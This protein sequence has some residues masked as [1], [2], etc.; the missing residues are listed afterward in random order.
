MSLRPLPVPKALPLLGLLFFSL[1]SS[2]SHAAQWRP[3]GPEGASIQ[4]VA[5]GAGGAVYAVTSQ[6]NVAAS[7]D[8]AA[9]WSQRGRLLGGHDTLVA[10]PARPGILYAAIPGALL[11]SADGGATWSEP[12]TSAILWDFQIAPSSPDVLYG[13]GG[14]EVLKSTDGGVSWTSSFLGGAFAFALAIDPTNPLIVYTATLEGVLRSDDGG[15]HWGVLQGS[16]DVVYDLAID[17]R[18]PA[19]LYGLGNGEVFKST[20]RGA[21]WTRVWEAPAGSYILPQ[22]LIVD[23]GSETVYM[24]D[25]HTGIYGS[26]DGGASWARILSLYG[27][28]DLAVDGRT[29]G[30]LYAGT[31]AG[32]VYRSDDR[33]GTWA[34]ANHGLREL[35]FTGV[36]ADPHKPGVLLAIANPDPASF[37]AFGS[38]I[39][40]RSTN[41]GATW[42]SPFGDP[43]NG[44]VSNEIV[45][46]PARPGAWYLATYGVLKSLNGGRTWAKASEGLRQIEF[47]HTLAAA[48][49]RRDTL[50]AISW[51]TYPLCN[52]PDCPRVTLY[53]SVDGGTHW[54]GAQ[55]PGLERGHVLFSLAVDAVNPAIVYAGGPHLFKSTDGGVSW[56]QTAGSL[57]GSIENLAADPFTS[58]TLYAAVYVPRGRRVYK[59]TDG[60]A[61]WKP[62]SG[63]LSVDVGVGRIV[64]DPRV[65]GTLYAATG[66]GVYVTRNGGALWTPMNEGWSEGFVWSLALDP[67]RP[68]VLYAGRTEGLFEY[69]SAPAA[70]P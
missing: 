35:A 13:T 59:T 55:V 24:L 53:H 20:D 15:A 22:K 51:D 60:G 46:D 52:S 42:S 11:K 39:L 6:G 41:G 8:G 50:Y 29:P 48:P 1:F 34:V 64:P 58:G 32:G 2:A 18:R 57:R 38:Q 61:T 27:V 19:T 65:P 31:Y 69:S 30:R 54:Q 4:A 49:S 45:A 5:S 63:G 67:L 12:L 26:P 66:K 37:P 62:A 68:G 36:A 33:G 44:P 14:K 3:I 23:P 16:P 47:V 17:P 21:S 25:N 7:S 56:S 70:A 40:L 9:S 43:N 28:L 10:D